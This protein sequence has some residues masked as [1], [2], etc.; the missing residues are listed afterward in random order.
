MIMAM[1]MIVIDEKLYKEDYIKKYTNCPFLIR[2]DNKQCLRYTD[3]DP[4]SAGGYVVIDDAS[5]LPVAAETTTNGRLDWRGTVKLSDGNTYY[6]IPPSRRSLPVVRN[7]PW[8]GR[9]PLPTSHKKSFVISSV[10]M[11]LPIRQP[12][13]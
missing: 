1:I 4:N 5:G 13:G 7:L 6:A 9:R 10:N 11:P 3:I 2:S 8:P 12:H